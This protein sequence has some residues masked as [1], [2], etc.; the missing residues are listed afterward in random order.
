MTIR[1][2]MLGWEA[3]LMVIITAALVVFGLVS[4]YGASSA[5]MQR[6][7]PIGSSLA[8]DQALLDISG[9]SKSASDLIPLLEKSGWLTK[10]EFAS[11]IVTDANKQEHFK[12]K[13]DY[14]GGE[15]VS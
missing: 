7:Q 10:T 14:K 1:D 3:R 11:P 5:L 13:A 4:V 6:G 12:I 2:R 15:P 8:L 9:M